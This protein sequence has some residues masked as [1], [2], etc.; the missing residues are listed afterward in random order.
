MNRPE[1]EDWKI[2][3]EQP[4]TKWVLAQISEDA[5]AIR[6]RFV[7]YTFEGQG[8]DPVMMANM[9]GQYG[10]FVAV[11]EHEYTQPYPPDWVRDAEKLK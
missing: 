11:L 5:E 7:A 1:Y 10:G 9:R 3:L 6:A 8:S 2:W 4:V